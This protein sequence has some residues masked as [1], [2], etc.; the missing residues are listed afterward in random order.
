[1]P[2]ISHFFSV[3]LA[4][5]ECSHPGAT[6]MLEWGALSVATSFTPGNRSAVDKTTE[7]TFMKN[8]KSRGG[9]GT[10]AGLSGVLKNQEA[11]QRWTRTMSEHTKYYQ[12][13]L[14]LTDMTTEICDGSSHKDL[15]KAEIA[16]N[17]KQVIK[18][19]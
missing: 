13:T 5:I 6:E 17:E 12:S 8:A 2:I 11:Y 9:G 16:K 3:F 10:S 19:I 18:T 4:N 1:M 14:S 15:R 7:E